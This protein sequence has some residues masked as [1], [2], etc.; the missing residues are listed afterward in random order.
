[1]G[2]EMHYSHPSE[3]MDEIARLTPTFAGVSYD[4][5][6]A[7]GSVQWPC[8]DEAPEGTPI[9]H[10]GSF[11]RGKGNFLITEYVP[12]DEKTRP[13]FPLLLTT[14]RILSQYN[15][16]A[17]TRRTGNSIWHEEDR[18]EIHPHD[19]EQRGIRDG[20]WVRLASRAGETSLRAKIT[21]RVA[22]GV[23][24]TT[25]H[26]P[27]TQANV[28]T[29]DYSDWATN[30]PEYKVT[31]VQVSP[32]NGPTKWQETYE[33]RARRSRRIAPVEAAT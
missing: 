17:Q 7:M 32:S 12:T 5:L 31:A 1:M 3:I 14:G 2:L 13:R 33:A 25:F 27:D 9:M 21:D 19:A 29:T 23:V 18:L 30:C 15:V 28:I 26:H 20:D 10:I 16:G 24:Y 8:N 11:V 22:L 4:K 6:E